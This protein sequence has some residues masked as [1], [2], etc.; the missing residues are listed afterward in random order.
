MA[1]GWAYVP[2]AAISGSR[3]RQTRRLRAKRE[4]WGKDRQ[5]LCRLTS[6][7]SSGAHRTSML[8]GVWGGSNSGNN[9]QVSIGRSE[10]SS[11][12][13]GLQHIY[14]VQTMTGGYTASSPS[15]LYHRVVR[16]SSNRFQKRPRG[17]SV[18]SSID[19]PNSAVWSSCD[20]ALGVLQTKLEARWFNQPVRPKDMGIPNYR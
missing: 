17:R 3:E 4:S 19:P 7:G 6:D 15:P 8:L 12:R 20:R 14:H 9:T 13:P 16:S 5:R 1:A 18:S 10:N 11:R 2:H